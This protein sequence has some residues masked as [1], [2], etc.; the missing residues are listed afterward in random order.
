MIVNQMDNQQDSFRDLLAGSVLADGK[1]I[2]EQVLGGGGFGITYK[3]RQQGLNRIVCIKE[4]FLDGKCVRHTH[5]RT[6]L[7]QGITKEVF[8]KYRQKFVEEAQI[9]A[10]LKHPNIVEVIDVFDE[11]NTSYMV[12]PFIE[13][14]TLHDL[15]KTKGVLNYNSAVNYLG[16]ISNAVG[17][18]HEL[19]IL[20]R[21]IKPE[22]IIITPSHNAVLIDFG[23]AREYIE[24]KTQVHTSM[25]T[26]GYA[27]PEQ[28]NAVSR[29]GSYSD[30]Y[31]L[32]ATYY[33]ALTKNTPLDAT[34]RHI[35]PMP[36]P[37][38]LNPTITEDANR[39]ILK[40]MA[41]K[42]ENRH[43]TITEFL[44]DLLG[45]RPSDPIDD[46]TGGTKSRIWLW[47][48][49]AAAVIISGIIIGVMASGGNADNNDNAEI[50]KQTTV[51]AEYRLPTPNVYWDNS[52]TQYHLWHNC[53]H[54]SN[55]V[56]QGSVEKAYK[57]GKKTICQECE[58]N[59]ETYKFYRKE[60]SGY[61]DDANEWSD[62][63]GRHDDAQEAINDAK[64]NYNKILEMRPDNNMAK[65]GLSKLSKIE[66]TL[67]KNRF[68]QG[69][70]AYKNGDYDKAKDYFTQ[71]YKN[72]SDANF[73]EWMEKCEE[74]LAKKTSKPDSTPKPNPTP[75]PT[76]NPTPTLPSQGKIDIPPPP[77]SPAAFENKLPEIQR[78]I[79]LNMNSVPSKS[80]K[81]GDIYK[82]QNNGRG[83]EGLGVYY[84]NNETAN[85][86]FYIGGWSGDKRNGKAIHVAR[87][88]YRIS[89]CPYGT[90]YY[91]GDFLNDLKSGIGTCY[92]AT[93]KVIYHGK[94]VDDVPTNDPIPFS[95]EFK[96][97]KI[98]GDYYF[99]E[100]KNGKGDGFG[101]YFS[102]NGTMW[103]GAWSNGN[104][105]KWKNGEGNDETGIYIYTSGE[106][107][108]SE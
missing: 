15:V 56:T 22:N 108:I 6:V 39:T 34:T 53:S 21:D 14:A 50:L 44:D 102:A 96:I 57:A 59:N 9:L 106:I 38:S 46:D 97:I 103:Y 107:I 49:L 80:Y 48:I 77:P 79:S 27:P 62:K 31:A 52:T 43:Q 26:K 23:S 104:K 88:G 78:L 105:T 66:E 51:V 29:K 100:T 33:Y 13:G 86:A 32:G 25:Y 99:G 4:F 72:C 65:D 37:K 1:Y 2:I 93:G 58:N 90:Q 36:E 64:L 74:K 3:A 30:I 91:V 35:D 98:D 10:K 19:K 89:N 47:I 60:A 8:E 81:N 84:H 83:R 7:L 55:N 17:Y 24:D 70:E 63:D 68:D 20:H 41:M 76:P 94:F 85:R 16:Q 28:Y 18:I 12:M 54:L 101:V 69:M 95:S 40:A 73:K 92:D 75:T 87:D 42:P 67:N 82:G 45:R 5:A 11:N 71:G 61:L